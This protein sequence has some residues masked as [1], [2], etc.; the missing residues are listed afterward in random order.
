MD[1]GHLIQLGFLEGVMPKL[2]LKGRARVS[3]VKVG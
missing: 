1:D 2:S 3:P